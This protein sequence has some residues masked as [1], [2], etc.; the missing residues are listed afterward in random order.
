MVQVSWPA[1]CQTG[2]T[3][4]GL[5]FWDASRDWIMSTFLDSG[6][7]RVSSGCSARKVSHSEKDEWKVKPSAVWTWLSGPR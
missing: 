5:A 7:T 6:W 1:N 2:R 4:C 3:P